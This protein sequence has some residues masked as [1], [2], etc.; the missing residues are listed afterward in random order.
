[1]KLDVAVSNGGLIAAAR[2]HAAY[3]NARPDETFD[4]DSLMQTF[5]RLRLDVEIA[6]GS[7]STSA[8]RGV[9]LDAAAVCGGRRRTSARRSAGS[10]SS[11]AGPRSA[12]KISR[13]RSSV[14][15]R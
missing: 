15:A 4:V 2:R 12:P 11:N 10:I 3:L 5:G 9:V 8:S 7:W 1:M 6:S 14:S 13:R